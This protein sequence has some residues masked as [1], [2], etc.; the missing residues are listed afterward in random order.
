MPAAVSAALVG[1]ARGVRPPPPQA[2]HRITSVRKPEDPS[3]DPY[4]ELTSVGTHFSCW[5]IVHTGGRRHPCP[6]GAADELP[7]AGRA[8]NGPAAPARPG[9]SAATSV[10]EAGAL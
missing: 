8:E 3:R 10:F 2:R 7:R 5:R 6:P 9:R 1:R 4:R